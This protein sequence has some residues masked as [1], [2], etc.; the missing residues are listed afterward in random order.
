MTN[1][2][3]ECSFQKVGLFDSLFT[4][5]V[6]S[7][8][9]R[10]GAQ[11]PFPWRQPAALDLFNLVLSLGVVP[12]CGNEALWCPISKVATL[13]SPAITAPSLWHL[14]ITR[15]SNIWFITTLHWTTHLP[16]PTRS[17][18]GRL[19]MVADILVSSL[20]DVLSSRSSTHTFV[21]FVDIQKA[22]DLS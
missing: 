13:L 20:V 19:P 7:V 10:Q 15:S 1:R 22:F 5:C 6:A 9:P 16:L 2:F 4:L 18:S 17:G 12:R 8:G 21:A 14:A 3:T 11:V